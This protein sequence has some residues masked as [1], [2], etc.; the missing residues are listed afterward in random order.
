MFKALADSQIAPRRGAH[1][2]LHRRGGA[3]RPQKWP[4][5]FG[6][7]C[8][9]N[10]AQMMR[11]LTTMAKR[12]NVSADF[13]AKVALACLRGRRGC[14]GTGIPGTN[15]LEDPE[16]T[17]FLDQLRTLIEISKEGALFTQLWAD[18]HRTS[19]GCLSRKGH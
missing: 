4:P 14:G 8:K 16:D 19:G 9:V 18:R 11:N 3:T 2:L 1:A 17:R 7:R 13:K 10:F 6:Q 15:L 12:R 5:K